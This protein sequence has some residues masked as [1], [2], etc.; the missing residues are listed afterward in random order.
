MKKVF[1]VIMIVALASTMAV[2]AAG[3]QETAPSSVKVGFIGPMTGDYANYGD[4]IS[5]GVLMAIEEKNATGGIAGKVK[6][7]LIIEDSEG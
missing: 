7:E 2:F 1:A 3:G 4:L 5:K 6:V